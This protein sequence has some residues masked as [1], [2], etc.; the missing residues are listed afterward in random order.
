ML[1]PYLMSSTDAEYYWENYKNSMTD[2]LRKILPKY[3]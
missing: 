3:L 1:T 2:K